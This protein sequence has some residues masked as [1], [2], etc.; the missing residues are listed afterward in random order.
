MTTENALVTLL[1]EGV[2]TRE[3]SIDSKRDLEDALRSACNDFIEHTSS[4]LAGPV[5]T[6]VEQC[7]SITATGGDLS[8]ESFMSGEYIMAVVTRTQDRLEPEL[9]EVVTQMSLYMDNAA[10]QSILLKPV[11]R[12][13]V[14]VLEDSRRFIND[15]AEDDNSAWP[16]G[17]KEKVLKIIGEIELMIKSASP[18]I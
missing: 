8:T 16:E 5:I 7:K 11:V 1:R 6:F 10:T 15:C 13:I 4:S 9:G 2:N 3:S 12:K 18:R 17:A 14:R